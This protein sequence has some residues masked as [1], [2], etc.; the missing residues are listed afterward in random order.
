MVEGRVGKKGKGTWK[1]VV[2]VK[3]DREGKG[4]SRWRQTEW[5]ILVE[6]GSKGRGR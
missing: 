3:E 1:R 5:K 4:E 6:E 2:E